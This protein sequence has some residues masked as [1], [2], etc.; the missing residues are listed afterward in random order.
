[1]QLAV[2]GR[3]LPR[4]AGPEAGRLVLARGLRGFADGMV[5]VLL[6]TLPAGPRVLARRRSARSSPAR[7]SVRRRSRLASGSS[8]NRAEPAARPALRVAG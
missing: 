2:P 1:M 5:S 8:G 6:A 3:F 7:C 4:D